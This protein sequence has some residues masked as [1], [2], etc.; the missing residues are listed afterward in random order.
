MTDY[1]E[2]TNSNEINS[3]NMMVDPNTLVIPDG[4]QQQ[5]P[6]AN[7]NALVIPDGGVPRGFG[8]MS[9]DY[10]PPGYVTVRQFNIPFG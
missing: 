10:G 9:A 2:N 4:A 6:T 3:A 7:P 5:Q 1:M 8:H